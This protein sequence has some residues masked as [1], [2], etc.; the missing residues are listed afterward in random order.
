MSGIV[1]IVNIDG[2]PVDRELIWRCTDFLSYRGPDAQQVHLDRNVALGHTLLSTTYESMTE[3]QPLTLD[4]KVWLIADARIDGREELLRQLPVSSVSKRN[5]ND[6][7]LILYAYEAW[8][9][10][11]IHH[12]IGDFV[13]AIWDTRSQS[14]LCA[15]DHLGV[16]PFF[17]AHVA[18]TF[19]FSNTL[20][21]LRL[22]SRVSDELDELVIG[23]YLLFGH[24]QDIST[25]TFRDIKRLPAGHTLTVLNGIANTR[26]Y[27]RPSDKNELRFRDRSSYVERFDELLTSAVEDRL[28]NSRVSVSM[29]G[30]LDSTSLAAIAHRSLN[31]NE[32]VRAFS[33]VYDS[34][35]PDEEH[36]YSQAAAAHIGI[37]V[38]HV[39][40]DRFPL[41]DRQIPSDMEQAEPFLLSPFA[42]QFNA[43]LRLCSQHGRIALTGFDGDTLMNEPANSYFASAARTFRF[44]EFTA[45]L[46]WYVKTQGRLPGFGIRGWLKRAFDG[47]KTHGFYPEW[48]DESF[49][50]R[51]NLAERLQ[52]GSNNEVKDADA[53][54]GALLGLASKVWAPLFEG[55]DP[56]ATRLAL[57]FRHPLIDLRLLEFLLSIPSIP[58]CLDKYILRQS[59]QHVLPDII[60]N[61]RKTPLAGDPALQMT[62][63]GSVRWLDSFEVSPQLSC[64]VNLNKRQSIADEQTT[65]GLWASLRVFALNHWLSNSQPTDRVESRTPTSSKESVSKISIA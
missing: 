37:P 23:D 6:A 44:K 65:E 50:K 39:V 1:G 26:C 18:N 32:S 64:Y 60:L 31:Q 3:S 34:L 20:T 55:Y 4:G 9:A 21:A 7:E 57:E 51:T 52:H 53:R 58:W 54:P 62:R 13:F 38:T 63:R 30:G 33:V 11:C 61:R 43:L 56:G 8:G 2:A 59:M 28:R 49:A 17:Y 35:I 12:L 41:F 24:N 14:L 10:A 47:T 5:P 42:G 25:T 48:I 27:W 15:R 45:A 36:Y 19:I 46:A 40:A 16:K 22:D 29:S